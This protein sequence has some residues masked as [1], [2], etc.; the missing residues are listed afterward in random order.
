MVEPLLFYGLLHYYAWRTPD[1][2]VQT[3]QA[4][5]Q[6]L[7]RMLGALVLGGALVGLIGM[8]Q[9]LGLNL[10]PLLGV[11]EV[12]GDDRILVEGVSRVSSVYGHPNNLGLFM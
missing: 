5:Q 8:L 11:K 1:G 10:V 12:V 4:G 9:F 2:A 6:F 3:P 7:F